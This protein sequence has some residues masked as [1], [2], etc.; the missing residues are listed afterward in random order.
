MTNLTPI[1][2]I[3]LFGLNRYFDELIF[4][5][6]K[7][8]LPS[9]ILLSGQK[10]IGKSTLAY[11]FINYVLS[12]EEEFKY[13][14]DSFKINVESNTYK[15]ILNKSNPNFIL[16]DI[17]SE[18]KSIDINQ[19]RSLISNLNKSSFNDKPRF[20]L[21]DNI[22]FLNVN[23]INA[24]LK[25]LEEPN[26]NVHF[27]LINNNK[28]IISTL[29]SR[30]INF[31]VSLSKEENLNVADLLLNGRLNEI[32]NK[33]LI[34][35]YSTPGKIYNLVKFAENNNYDLMNTNLKDLLK[36]LINDSQY[37]Q[38]DELT[39]NLLFELIE[40]YFVKI[41]LSFSLNINDKY[42]H[43]LKRASDTKKFNLDQES[44]F[45]EFKDDILNG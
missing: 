9:K 4:L 10:G 6:Q 14:A 17:D 8:C 2:Q 31:N 23:S 19:I 25:T 18:K 35:Y 24:M 37:K 22:E 21:I 45:M 41:N 26:L 7:K 27:I 20:V 16:I 36:L 15:T 39:K 12:M 28:K 5:H 44:L 3:N 42:S 30:C 32:I 33:D 1:N 11:H 13:D 38:K 29:L 40:L 43:F 34:N